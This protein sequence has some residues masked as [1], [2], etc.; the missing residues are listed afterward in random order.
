MVVLPASRTTGGDAVLATQ[1]RTVVLLVETEDDYRAEA[2]DALQRAGFRVIACADPHQAVDVIDGPK[3]IDVLLTRV[4]MPGK[5]PHGFALASMARLKRPGIRT[6]LYA[7]TRS[8][9]PDFEVEAAGGVVRERPPR[10]SDLAALVVES[11]LAK[12]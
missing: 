8:D 3:E 2:A 6:V 4:V 10:G 7:R 5:W 12:A 9:F 1:A 11:D